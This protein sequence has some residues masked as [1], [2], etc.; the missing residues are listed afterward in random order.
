MYLVIRHEDPLNLPD[1]NCCETKSVALHFGAA[2]QASGLEV[3]EDKDITRETA[4]NLDIVDQMGRELILPSFKL[5]GY[6]FS[7]NHP[8][9]AKIISWKYARKIR[10]MQRK[11]MSGERNGESYSR[12]KV[13][14]L[15]LLRMPEQ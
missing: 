1:V 8:W 5:I 10:K 12:F 2:L 6:A 3:L 15:L 7:S 9:L 13:Y 11:Y 4:P 14:R